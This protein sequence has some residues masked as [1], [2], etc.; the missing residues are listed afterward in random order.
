[1]HG[2]TVASTN[3]TTMVTTD[4]IRISLRITHPEITAQEMAQVVGGSLGAMG[5]KGEPRGRKPRVDR[6]G[7]DRRSP[8]P[9]HYASFDFGMGDGDEQ[10]AAALQLIESRTEEIAKLTATGGGAALNIFAAPA[11]WWGFEIEPTSLELLVR[12]GVTFGIE[13]HRAKDEAGEE[14]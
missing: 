3:P 8:W 5:V 9:H 2:R 14:T 6:P 4:F 10:L 12:C 7:G 13:I 1:M 11:S